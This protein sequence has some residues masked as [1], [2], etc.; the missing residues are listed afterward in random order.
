MYIF[1]DA[2]DRFAYIPIRNMY[3]IYGLFDYF[4][5]VSQHLNAPD[6][7]VQSRCVPL[8]H[9]TVGLLTLVSTRL[10][11]SGLFRQRIY[12]LKPLWGH[13]VAT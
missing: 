7:Y 4:C 5:Q 12:L 3:S 10:S 2:Q 8:T 6:I 9:I 1:E 13:V 11:Q